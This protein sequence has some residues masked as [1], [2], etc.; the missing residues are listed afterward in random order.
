[1]YLFQR[2]ISLHSA[3]Q[4]RSLGGAGCTKLVLTINNN[5]NR[6]PTDQSLCLLITSNE[7]CILKANIQA[8]NPRQS[9]SPLL[10]MTLTAPFASQDDQAS[11][12]RIPTTHHP[13]PSHLLL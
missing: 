11:G 3:Q 13:I 2:R 7:L 9:E 5:T 4:Q 1:M 10:Q 8:R 12:L 6:Y